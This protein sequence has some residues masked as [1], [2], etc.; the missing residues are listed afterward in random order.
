[1]PPAAETTTSTMASAMV[2][3][4]AQST[5]KDCKRW[6]PPCPFCVQ[7]APHPSPV[8][9]DWSEEDWDGDIEREKKNKERERR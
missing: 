2:A 4:T 8:D 9:S 1:M 3:A 7:S 5:D 6:G